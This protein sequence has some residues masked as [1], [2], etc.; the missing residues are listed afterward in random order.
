MSEDSPMGNEGNEAEPDS[1]TDSGIS[2]Q[3]P[4]GRE[5]VRSAVD[6]MVGMHAFSKGVVPDEERF[7]QYES[8]LMATFHPRE[9]AV[10]LIVA[11]EEL[12]TVRSGLTTA[13]REDPDTVQLRRDRIDQ[14]INDA[15]RAA[16]PT[17]K[18]PPL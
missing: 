5:L 2:L 6:R 4:K 15:R 8:S 9:I 12:A 16:A 18:Q 11:L 17:R 13:V 14:A 10:I 1:V 3:D 7:A